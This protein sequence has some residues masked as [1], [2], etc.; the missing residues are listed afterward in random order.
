MLNCPSVNPILPSP[1]TRVFVYCAC[2][3]S[4]CPV[5]EPSPPATR[6]FAGTGT[7]AARRRSLSSA[8]D[9]PVVPSARLAITA[10][11]PRRLA[12]CFCIP[13]TQSLLH[14]KELSCWREQ[15]LRTARTGSAGYSHAPASRTHAHCTRLARAAS[16]SCWQLSLASRSFGRYQFAFL[17]YP[18]IGNRESLRLFF[19]AIEVPHR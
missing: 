15:R 9:S 5:V 17:H 16:R 10:V 1:D 3:L 19:P 18:G 8:S 12:A 7:A 13:Q 4:V 14:S 2:P 11:V 6:P